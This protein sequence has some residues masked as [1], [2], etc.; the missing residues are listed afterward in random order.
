MILTSFFVGKAANL[1]DWIAFD[2]QFQ[3]VLEAFNDALWQP[4][5]A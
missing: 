1:P 2:G 3:P 5:A 4:P